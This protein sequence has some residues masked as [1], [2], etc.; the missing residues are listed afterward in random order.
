[1]TRDA[2]PSAME[3]EIKLSVPPGAEAAL[4]THPSLQGDGEDPARTRQEVTTYFDTPREDLARNGAILRIRRIGM[5]RIQTLKLRRTGGG[6]FSRG[7]WEW[8]VRD[9]TPDLARLVETPLADLVNSLDDLRP[10]FTTEV[11]RTIRTLRADGALVELA[12]DRGAIRA[13]DA[14]EEIR[15]LELELKEGDAAPLYR[16]AASLQEDL[17][18]TLGAEAKS[19]R[20]WRLRTGQ[21]RAPEKLR[22]VPLPDGVT[23]GDALRRILGAAL[24]N[25]LA[26]QPAAAARQIEGVHNMRIAIRRLRSALVLFRSLLDREKEEHFTGELRR[27]GRVLGEARDWD[28]FCTETLHQAEEDGVA[29]PLLAQLREAAEAQR[30]AAYGYLT[31]ELRGPGLTALMLDMA[32]WAETLPSGPDERLRAP[33]SDI[34]P[35]LEARLQRKALKR[36]RH[37]RRRSEAELHS[38]RKAL[39]K[40]R[41]GVEFMAPLHRR[42]RVKAYLRGLKALQEQLGLLNDASVASSL[43]AKLREAHTALVP[44]AEAL[45]GWA[46]ARR[47]QGR[48][49]LRQGWR[50]FKDTKLPA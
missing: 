19:D 2:A 24:T 17:K 9:D 5:Q 50:A 20:G 36:G 30:A 40:L 13:G 43:T 23:A 38:L 31:T 39:K 11:E 46:E 49:H 35:E 45:T 10:V 25:L 14:A 15:E 41:Y 3:L 33:L 12:F 47:T 28:V 29:P 6:P 26:N 27:L 34:A 7:E 1:M 16:L 44:A 21:P 48:R 8:T 4:D 22:E 18:L 32:A 42:K 37:I